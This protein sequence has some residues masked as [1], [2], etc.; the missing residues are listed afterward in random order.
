MSTKIPG[1]V[2]LGHILPHSLD[3]FTVLCHIQQRVAYGVTLDGTHVVSGV[4]QGTVQ[5]YS[6]F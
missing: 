6:L 2:H 3:A 1:M 5:G 4:P